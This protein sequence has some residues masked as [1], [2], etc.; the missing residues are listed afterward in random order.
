VQKEADERAAQRDRRHEIAEEMARRAKEAEDRM[1]AQAAELER[2]RKEATERA[3]H[4]AEQALQVDEGQQDDDGE[5]TAEDLDK[6]LDEMLESDAEQ[7][8]AGTQ[9]EEERVAQERAMALAQLQN[10]AENV[11]P[12]PETDAPLAES[13]RP[14]TQLDLP[15]LIARWREQAS[16]LDSPTEISRPICQ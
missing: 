8:A 7:R 5:V 16:R 4:D 14:L 13:S 6:L 1:T 11:A 15:S 10:E 12:L 2:L 9:E 3:A